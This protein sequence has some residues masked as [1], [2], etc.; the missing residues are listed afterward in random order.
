MKK[1]FLIRHAKS[2]WDESGVSDIKR[3][4]N[5]RGKRDAPFMASLLKKEKI[6]PD[7][8]YSSP[9]NRAFTTAEIFAE[10][11]GYPQKKIIIESSIYESGIREL[12]MIINSVDDKNNSVFLFGHNPTF[13]IY[14]NHLG[15]KYIANLPTCGI[16]GIQFETNSWKKIERGNGKVF[17]FE[18]PKKYFR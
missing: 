13:T 17:Y 3:T 14:A 12:E 4:L 8:I 11:I 5:K 16:V 1:L 18:Y 6:F 10:E 15:D 2:N 9:A 7:M